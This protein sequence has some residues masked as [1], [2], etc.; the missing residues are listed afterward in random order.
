MFVRL[1]CIILSTYVLLEVY[2]CVLALCNV[3][4]PMVFSQVYVF[5]FLVC[6]CVCWCVS[7]CVFFVPVCVCAMLELGPIIMLFFFHAL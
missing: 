1:I 6:L 4:V 2:C 5:A 7:L 3:H